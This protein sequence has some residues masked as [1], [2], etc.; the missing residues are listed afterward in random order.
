[1]YF[2]STAFVTHSKCTLNNFL[3]QLFKDFS[4]LS[5]SLQ[6]EFV[7]SLDKL[8]QHIPQAELTDAFEGGFVYD[9]ENWLRFRMVRDLGAIALPIYPP[10]VIHAVW[11]TACILKG[12]RTRPSIVGYKL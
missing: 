4:C 10:R 9:H 12:L 3:P 5:F 11:E 8:Y 1:M 6:L 7:R 2:L